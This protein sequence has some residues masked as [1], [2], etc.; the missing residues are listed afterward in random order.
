MKK[1][2]FATLLAMFFNVSAFAQIQ[3][4]LPVP[5]S[6]SQDVSSKT[7]K[8][9]DQV[10]FDVMSDVYDSN[11][12][13]AIPAGT[14]AFGSV[15]SVKKPKGFCKGGKLEITINYLT[16]ANGQK[17]NLTADN[18]LATGKSKS[19]IHTTMQICYWM[20]WPILIDGVFIK[21]QP[22]ILPK[23]TSVQAYTK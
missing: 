18:L 13:L 20:C 22:A 5:L 11:G 15:S 10:G 23:G 19:V 12:E 2:I 16:L 3:S 1:Y 9:G 17:V 4:G 8:T 21:G 7:L 14:T 6:L